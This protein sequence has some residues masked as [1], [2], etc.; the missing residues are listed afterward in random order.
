MTAEDPQ[1]LTVAKQVAGEVNAW[2]KGFLGRETIADWREQTRVTTRIFR[3]RGLHL[4]DRHIAHADGRGFSASIADLVLYVTNNYAALGAQRRS[5]VLYLPK[6][7]TA[8]EAAYWNLLL[9][10]LEDHLSLKRG[11]IVCYVLV[12]QIEACFP[13]EPR[14]VRSRRG[15]S[16]WHRSITSRQWRFRSCPRTSA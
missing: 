9:D 13:N 8:A 5:I 6:I 14:P 3:A 11:T 10:T 15:R 12:E 2:A 16:A 4:D 1:F 7:Q